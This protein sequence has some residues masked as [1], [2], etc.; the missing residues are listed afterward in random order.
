[1]SYRRHVAVMTILGAVIVGCGSSGGDTDVAGTTP[2]TSPASDDTQPEEQATGDEP[3]SVTTEPE[4]APPT[5]VSQIDI[6]DPNTATF[7]IDG[8]TVE[9]DVQCFADSSAVTVLSEHGIFIFTTPETSGVAIQ[10][11][12]SDWIVDE[13]EGLGSFSTLDVGEDRITGTATFF[14]MSDG[15][16]ADGEFSVV[17]GTPTAEE[18]PT[19]DE[20]WPGYG[21]AVLDGVSYGVDGIC[22]IDDGVLYFWGPDGEELFDGF[23]MLARLDSHEPGLILSTGDSLQE[24]DRWVVNVATSDPLF[25]NPSGEFISFDLEAG[26]FQGEAVLESAARDGTLLGESAQVTFDIGC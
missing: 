21:E 10:M 11:G 3:E 12:E 9:F 5:T 14:E 1:M 16:T 19:V 7:T 18:S 25:G 6:G 17:C 26:R 24:L 15:T 4:E 8:T 22:E 23:A 13:R 2:E 20:S